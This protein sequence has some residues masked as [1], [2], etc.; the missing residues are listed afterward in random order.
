MKK[1]GK[2]FVAFCCIAAV[3]ATCTLGASANTVYGRCG[4]YQFVGHTTLNTDTCTGYTRIGRAPLYGDRKQIKIT[5]NGH[6]E[7][8]NSSSTSDN[9]V[10]ATLYQIGSSAV[11][12][13]QVWIDS[14]Y[15]SLYTY[16]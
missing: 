4:D 15:N 13:H 11:G 7:T 2:R 16:A 12:Y 5:S 6:S 1:I 8:Q 3:A 14:S 9:T 10:Y